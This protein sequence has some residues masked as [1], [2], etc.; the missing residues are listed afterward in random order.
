MISF[1]LD[2]RFD[3]FLEGFRESVFFTASL[4]FPT[5]GLSGPIQSPIIL[6]LF[7]EHNFCHNIKLRTSSGPIDTRHK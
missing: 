3:Q 4:L 2:Y 1:F 6:V 5:A 7:L